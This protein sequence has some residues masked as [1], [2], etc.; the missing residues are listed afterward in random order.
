MKITLLFLILLYS[1]FFSHG[2][3][4]NVLFLGNS[5]TYYYNL[6]Q[7]IADMAASAGDTLFFDSNSMPGATFYAHQLNTVSQ[8]KIM[9]GNW[10]YVILQGQSLELFGQS[11]PYP[12]PA[13]GVLDSMINHYSPCGETMFYMTWGRKN[14]VGSYTYQ[15]MDSMISLNYMNL[16]DTLNAVVSPVSKVWNFIRQNYPAIELYDPDESHPSLAGSY[17][18]ACCFY[19]AIFR[20][21]PTLCTFNSTLAATDAANIK[22]AAKVIVYDSLLTW[23]IGEY[24]SIFINLNCPGTGLPEIGKVIWKMYPNPATTS[25]TLELENEDRG[26]VQLFNSLG[27]LLSETETASPLII[28]IAQLPKGLYFLRQKGDGKGRRFIKQ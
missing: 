28:N 8:N 14:G 4:K 17:A 6:P 3:S 16:A 26:P 15:T 12:S 24:D 11:N 7:L 2:Q 1:T 20:K 13:A 23:H 10:D 25:I 18:A 27:I 9:M 21:D 22:S 5:Y 19:S